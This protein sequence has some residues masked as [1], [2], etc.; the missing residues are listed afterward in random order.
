[1]VL[2]R[3]FSA[4]HKLILFKNGS[5]IILWRQSMRQIS[6]TEQ[7]HNHNGKAEDSGCG[8]SRFDTKTRNE[9]QEG[10]HATMV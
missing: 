10:K 1:M 4:Q 2:P 7:Q 5:D 8:Y 3:F 6:C 9:Y